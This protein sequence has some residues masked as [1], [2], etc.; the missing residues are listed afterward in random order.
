MHRPPA[1]VQHECF[2]LFRQWTSLQLFWT[3]IARSHLHARTHRRALI[4]SRLWD[5]PRLCWLRSC[6]FKS[7]IPSQFNLLPSCHASPLSLHVAHMHYLRLSSGRH[8]QPW[9]QTP[10]ASD[11]AIA[12]ISLVWQRGRGLWFGLPGWGRLA[13]IR[14]WHKIWRWT[15]V[16]RFRIIW[17]WAKVQIFFLILELL[18]SRMKQN[19][20]Q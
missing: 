11:A 14:L 2:H 15:L 5:Q 6:D 12:G 4:I 9:N 16:S 18:F 20:E 10:R 19:S 7:G 17:K 1:R 3:L 13:K 8:L